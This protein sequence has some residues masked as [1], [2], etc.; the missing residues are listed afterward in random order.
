MHPETL[1]PAAEGPEEQ[2]CV[3]QPGVEQ[4]VEES[5]GDHGNAGQGDRK[6]GADRRPREARGATG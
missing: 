5:A 3:Q 4:G 2:D 1:E 6:E